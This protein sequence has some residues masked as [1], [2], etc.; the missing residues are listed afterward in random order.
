MTKLS[1]KLKDLKE[2]GWTEDQ[3][4]KFVEWNAPTKSFNAIQ[5]KIIAA[6]STKEQNAIN[7]QE[8]GSDD[9]IDHTHDLVPPPLCLAGNSNGFGLQSS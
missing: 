3:L 5:S 8:E 6:K 1:D 2:K 9:S 7:Q 4:L